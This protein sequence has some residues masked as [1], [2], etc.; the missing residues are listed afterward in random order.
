METLPGPRFLALAVRA[1]AYQGV[2]A[3]RAANQQDDSG[4]AHRTEVK[5]V[6][7]NRNAVLA[8]PAFDGLVSWGSG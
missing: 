4:Q 1:F 7:P 2:M 8:H 5:Q 3:A 6:D